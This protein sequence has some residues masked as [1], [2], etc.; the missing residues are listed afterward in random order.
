MSSQPVAP[1]SL[2]SGANRG[3]GAE[4]SRQLAAL[5]HHVLVGSRVVHNGEAI[6]GEI[7]SHGGAATVLEL[8]VTSES[9]VTEAEKFVAATFGRLDVLI[10]NAAIMYDDW[11]TA[12]AADFGDVRTALDTNLFGAWRMTQA[13]IP[14]L[15][16]SE[17]PRIVNVSSGS[18][19]LTDMGADIP[20]YRVSKVGLN[21]LTRMFAAELPGFV[22]NSVCPGWL[23][24]DMG[25]PGG[26][27]IGPG[28]ADIV[29]AALLDDDGPT[30]AN[31]EGRAPTPW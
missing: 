20:A 6:A 7:R 10:N 13:F 9:Q 21:S 22:V 16:R 11:Q 3:I 30:G 24:T 19:R 25:G 4:V 5:G 2:V 26:G 8:D 29:A 12:T 1:V 14:L 15:R 17:H 28:A 31:L 23:A 27:P 18:G